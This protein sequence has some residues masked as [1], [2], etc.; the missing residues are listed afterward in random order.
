MPA[1][2]AATSRS[3]TPGAEDSSATPASAPHSADENRG[4]TR[5]WGSQ[6]PSS[7]SPEEALPPTPPPGRADRGPGKGSLAGGGG[8]L[9]AS[10]P[11]GSPARRPRP[12]PRGSRR[13][14]PGAGSCGQRPGCGPVPH[15]QPRSPAL[16]PS[17]VC[18]RAS[19]VPRPRVHRNLPRRG[20]VPRRGFRRRPFRFGPSTSGCGRA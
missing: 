8:G 19:P 13:G 1:D 11:C 20:T 17:P 4:S 12:P 2:P 10:G 16:T 5:K 7:T 3:P 9:W 18:H 15:P 6:G 14:H